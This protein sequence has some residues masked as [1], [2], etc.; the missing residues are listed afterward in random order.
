MTPPLQMMIRYLKLRLS[1][2]SDYDKE[3][4]PSSA[5]LMLAPFTNSKQFGDLV[6]NKTT[7]QKF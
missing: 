7:R 6:D 5:V 2:Q 3:E 1:S 4:P